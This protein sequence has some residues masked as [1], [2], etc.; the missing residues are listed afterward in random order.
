MHYAEW[1]KPV[2]KSY[3]RYGYISIILLKNK[4]I[5]TKSRLAIV[6]D[7]ERGKGLM[8]KGKQFGG[9]IIVLYLI[10]VLIIWIY[11]DVKSIGL[12][13]KVYSLNVNIKI[14][15]N[16]MIKKKSPRHFSWVKFKK[17]SAIPYNSKGKILNGNSVRKLS[18][19]IFFTNIFTCRLY[20]SN[21][22]L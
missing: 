17:L 19:Y 11:S 20:L 16:K 8:I 22:L 18:K 1:K 6:R 2:S 14:K 15:Q 9:D 21:K 5:M 3:M 4:T 10:V 12:H 7:E 13:R